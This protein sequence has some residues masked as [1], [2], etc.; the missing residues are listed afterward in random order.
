MV[1]PT[2]DGTGLVNAIHELYPATST[3]EARPVLCAF[4]WHKSGQVSATDSYRMHVMQTNIL[5]D[6]E[7][8]EF[9]IIPRSV[10]D[11]LDAS[12]EWTVFA[13]AKR[14]EPIVFGSIDDGRMVF[15]RQMDGNAP[16]PDRLFP[17]KWTH[18]SVFT[19]NALEKI[20][21]LGKSKNNNPM[22][23][24]GDT[25]INGTKSSVIFEGMNKLPMKAGVRQEFLVDALNFMDDNRLKLRSNNPLRPLVISP[26]QPDESDKVALVMPV[27]LNE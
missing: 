27:R 26:L 22:I 17:E 2:N 10:K 1:T 20:K 3:E 5:H 8:E 9:L 21:W 25:A 16:D 18:E 15:V 12:T 6:T 19:P 7:G 24:E 13:P 14:S 11:Y 4:H 23:V